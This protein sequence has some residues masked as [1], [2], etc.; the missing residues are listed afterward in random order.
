MLF[1]YD[2]CTC[3]IVPK[4]TVLNMAKF[5][6]GRVF[7]MQTLHSILN[8]PEYASLISK[9]ISGAKYARIRYMQELHR[10]LKKSQYGWICLNRTW[11]CLNMSDF[12]IIDR[13]LN[14]SHTIH[15][16]RSFYK[17]MSTYWE[18]SVFKILSKIYRL[19]KH[20][21]LYLLTV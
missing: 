16:A 7:K 14:I 9:Y 4:Q 10:V 11:I 5:E 13:V 12:T 17:L 18:M 20:K 19:L 15:S 6:Y 21:Y 8:M 2:Y 3:L 1:K